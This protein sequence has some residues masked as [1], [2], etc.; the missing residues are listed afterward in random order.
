MTAPLTRQER[1]R[2]LL[3]LRVQGNAIAPQSRS[4]SSSPTDARVQQT[5]QPILFMDVPR[6]RPDSPPV[7]V[8]GPITWDVKKT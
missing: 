8:R 4:P 5:A 2:D 3:A 1:T 6:Q 7:P